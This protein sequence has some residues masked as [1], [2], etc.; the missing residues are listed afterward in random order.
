M[1][2]PESPALLSEFI[3]W[4]QQNKDGGLDCVW[5]RR[6]VW[7][8]QLAQKMG[9]HYE[10]PAPLFWG[11]K[12]QVV[13]GETVS[14]GLLTFGYAENALTALMLFIISDRDSVVDIGTHFGYEAM[15][16]CRLVGD[17]GSVVCF[18]PNPTAADMAHKNLSKYPQAKLHQK[19]VG[20]CLGILKLQNKPIQESAFNSITE[21]QQISGFVEVSVTTLDKEFEDRTKAIDFVKV[22]VE[23]FELDVLKGAHNILTEDAP[24]LVLEADMPVDG[25]PGKRAFEL[26]THL[27]QYGYRA[28]SFDFDSQ[29]RCEPLGELSVNHANILFVHHS[30]T[31]PLLSKHQ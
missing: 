6:P 23:G 29:F 9:Q 24:I 19:A 1:I 12:M 10:A 18:E 28:F 17:A 3:R 2:N 31:P 5:R 14:R 15:L 7:L 22:D 4:R 16:A 11:E 13:T 27:E 21:T 26:A 25:K 8:Y 20:S 30:K